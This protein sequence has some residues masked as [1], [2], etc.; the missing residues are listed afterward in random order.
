MPLLDYESGLQP[1]QLL[2]LSGEIVAASSLSAT[3]G[4]VPGAYGYDPTVLQHPPSL[5]HVAVPGRRITDWRIKPKRR[6]PSPKKVAGLL[7][8]Y[9]LGE[10]DSATFTAVMARMDS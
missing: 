3:L 7:A 6:R 2:H 9:A 4:S 8:L 1:P 10:I 5:G